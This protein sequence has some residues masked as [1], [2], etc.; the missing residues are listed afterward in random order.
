MSKNPDSISSYNTNHSSET[1]YKSKMD[2]DL[3]SGLY[4]PNNILADY[5][6]M[7]DLE[8]FEQH[9]SLIEKE[10][11]SPDTSDDQLLKEVDY[12]FLTACLYGQIGI[13]EYCLKKQFDPNISSDTGL[14]GLHYACYFHN[15]V[16][17]SM[18]LGK[19][20]IK[21]EGISNTTPTP[22]VYACISNNENAALL[23]LEHDADPSKEFDINYLFTNTA[24][25]KE[26]VVN[27]LSARQKNTVLLERVVNFLYGISDDISIESD[28]SQQ[29]RSCNVPVTTCT[30]LSKESQNKSL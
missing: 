28:D 27:Y 17:A 2:Q 5:A 7:G 3:C 21:V 1:L 13:V 18:L 25:T 11:F 22:F 29:P 12:A 23:L 30:T 10:Y 9:F 20:K 6:R 24:G 19:E 26:N 8:K 16:I 4:I 14:T 15:N